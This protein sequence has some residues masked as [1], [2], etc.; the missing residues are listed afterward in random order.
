VV[1]LSDQFS[2]MAAPHAKSI[3][4]PGWGDSLAYRLC[5]SK[6]LHVFSETVQQQITRTNIVMR[7]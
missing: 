2:A 4:L 1:S 6:H 3:L 7:I 5:Q